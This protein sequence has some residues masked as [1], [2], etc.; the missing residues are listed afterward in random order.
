VLLVGRAEVCGG[1]GTLRR[2]MEDL[3]LTRKLGE[4]SYAVVYEGR[5]SS[6]RQFA[7]KELKDVPARCVVL[8]GR[9]K[10][11][12]RLQNVAAGPSASDC[13]K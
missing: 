5:D 2:A 8:G 10:G 3:E 7:V 1:R 9:A 4:G 12:V 6:G 11:L 13:L